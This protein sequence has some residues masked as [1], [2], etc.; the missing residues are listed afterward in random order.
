MRTFIEENPG[1]ENHR[2]LSSTSRRFPWA[3]SETLRRLVG[4]CTAGRVV[5]RP[6]AVEKPRKAPIPDGPVLQPLEQVF[7]L[8]PTENRYEQLVEPGR[9]HEAFLREHG[10]TVLTR[11]PPEP[12]GYL[13]LGHAKSMFINFGY[14]RLRGGK[15]YLRLD[16]T[17]PERENAEYVAA[18]KDTM[19]WLGHE[20]FAVTH[21]SDYFGRMYETALRL[22]AQGLLYVDDQ[23]PDQVAAYRE[24]RRDPPC[25]D[26]PPSESLRLFREMSMGL[27]P[28]GSLTVRMRINMQD[29][30][31]NMRDPIAYRI[32]YHDHQQCGDK[33]CVYPS[34]DFAHCLNDS[35]EHITHSICTLEFN[36]RRPSYDWLT[37]VAGGYRPMQWEFSRLNLTH[38]VMSKRRLL[39][40]VNDHL[41]DGWNDPR[42]P[43]LV[44]LRRRGYTPTIINTFCQL[45]GVSRN[46]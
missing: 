35:F 17:N 41:V 19:R 44:G 18:I 16:D 22:M 42:M 25:R 24:Q 23:T 21:A 4:E 3:Q 40:L 33:W 9:A 7:A 36:I 13:H 38:T 39:K 34:Y 31:P 12:N 43:T 30:N 46:D 37:H 5:A 6:A 10:A 32:K 20:P 26:R 2:V 45:C 15:T 1:A 27:W 8:V 29:D 11:F 28:E 14:A